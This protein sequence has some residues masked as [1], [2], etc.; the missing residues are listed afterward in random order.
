MNYSWVYRYFP[1]SIAL[2]NERFPKITE[3]YTWLEDAGFKINI[4]VNID[5]KKFKFTEMIEE[6]KNKDMSQLQ[7]ISETEYKNG[8]GKMEEDS[9]G[10]DHIIGDMAFTEVYA[11][12]L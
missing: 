11:E 1:T 8:L 10:N 12:K 7:I 4:R 6:V 5:V 9:K 2:D 3:L